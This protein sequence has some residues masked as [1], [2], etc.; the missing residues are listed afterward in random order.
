M[1]LM[2]RSVDR[3]LGLLSVATAMAAVILTGCKKEFDTPPVRTIP[4]GSVLTVD[5]LR[6][7][8]QGE[9]VRF[10]TDMSVYGVITADEANGNFYRE[11]FMQDHTAAINVR[12]LN[13]GGL[14][15]GDS[16][17][18]YLKGTV[19]SNYQGMLQLDSV[20]VDN[21]V[22][23]QATQVFKAPRVVTMSE[24]TPAL[25]GQLVRLDSVEFITSELC[26]TYADAENQQSEN[27]N[28]TDCNGA[29]VI[30]RTSGFADFAG[31]T[32]PQG[33]GSIV[34]IL[35]QYSTDM[36]LL[37]RRINEVQLTGDRC[38]PGGDPPCPSVTSVMEDFNNEIDNV[39][40]ALPCW[41]NTPEI[42]TRVWRGDVFNNEIYAQATA[43]QSSNATDVS[44]L[45]T[46]P[47]EFQSGRTLSFRSQRAFGVNGHE[48]FGV[49]L[50][51]DFSGDCV[52]AA[53]WTPI[54]CPYAT[55]STPD[56]TWVQSG[57]VVLDPYLPVGYSGSFV[58]GFKYVGS[59]PG[60]QTTNYRIDDVVI[61]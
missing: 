18:I 2:N 26:L 58:V 8:Y 22:F 16:V 59:G 41:K 51:T 24:L 19:L 42:G 15:L 4:V 25:Q 13:P 53:T 55:S 6:S 38:T 35:G 28:V 14:Y 31:E 49:Y 34:A 11:V 60:G 30:V 37:I 57:A 1:N 23:K 33:N 45:I 5:S 48:A 3:T 43:Y 56:F 36:Q 20:D 61:Q 39:D 29:Q 44:W 27:R 9:R 47:V 21:N 32:V 40:I 54:S 12:L 10:T 7:L 52:G 50:S 46:P 17:R